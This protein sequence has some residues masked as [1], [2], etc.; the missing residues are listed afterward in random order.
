MKPSSAL[1]AA[2]ALAAALAALSTTPAAA[3]RARDTSADAVLLTPVSQPTEAILDGRAWRC[4]G[5]LCKGFS[6]GAPASQPPVQECRR[7]ARKLGALAAYRSGPR[8]LD[9]TALAACNAA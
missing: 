8:T 3:A 1:L 7:V 9:A 4:E 6:A 2:A 5:V